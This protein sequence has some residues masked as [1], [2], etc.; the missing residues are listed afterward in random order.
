MSNYALSHLSDAWKNA[1]AGE[2]VTLPDGE[3]EVI[4]EKA[5]VSVTKSGTQAL[6][7]TLSTIQ[8]AEKVRK[9]SYL[10]ENSLSMLKRDFKAVG[11]DPDLIDIV[12]LDEW[13][14]AL[15]GSIIGVQATSSQKD[16]R[17]Y[18]NVAFKCLIKASGNPFP[19]VA[20]PKGFQQIDESRLPF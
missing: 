9:V 1:S 4:I 14:A 12:R 2:F 5:E 13:A 18:H 19:D 3:H 7:W 6:E 10:T 8:T 16:G 17:T 11:V 20:Q 15:V